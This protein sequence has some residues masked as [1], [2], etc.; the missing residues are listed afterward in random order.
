MDVTWTKERKLHII[1]V[2][3]SNAALSSSGLG[4]DDRR[5]RH[6][7]L[8]YKGKKKKSG[9]VVALLAH[10]RGL[11]HI[12]EFYGRAGIFAELVADTQSTRLCDSK[13][14]LGDEEVSVV[15]DCIQDLADNITSDTNGHL[16]FKGRPVVFAANP[17]LLAEL[18]RRDIISKAGSEYSVDVDIFHEGHCAPL[19]HDKGSQQEVAEGTGILP[20]VFANAFSIE[21]CMEVIG[22]FHQ[23]GMTAVG[24]MNAGS[25]GAGIEF[26]PS[27]LSEDEISDRIAKLIASASKKYGLDVLKS[28][29]PIQFFE[30]AEST[31]YML[32]GEPHLWDLRLQCLLYPGYVEITPCVIRLCPKPFD[33]EKFEWDS[34]VSNLTGRDPIIV[35]RSLRSPAA[36]RRSQPGSVLES[37]GICK[38][39]HA[40]IIRS[41]AKWCD[42]A[43]HFARNHYGREQQS[44]RG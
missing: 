18:A 44:P 4:R 16:Y 6:M 14:A 23:K 35:G 34:V 17:N 7:F 1:E 28:M 39:D 22:N 38:E 12:A 19:V 31:P 5:A 29:F 41:C 37:V 15:C 33:R 3:G 20:L 10:Q 32:Y 27:F 25:G 26:F 8:A 42:Q 24:K 43:W 11:I 2:N 13:E 40:E 21:E 30:F 9:S 36:M